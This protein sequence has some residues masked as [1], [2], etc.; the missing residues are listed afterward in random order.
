M[1]SI[2]PEAFEIFEKT[3]ELIKLYPELTD[4]YEAFLKKWKRSH[5][6]SAYEMLA[7]E[8]L[9]AIDAEDATFN[10]LQ[11]FVKGLNGKKNFVA[12]MKDFVESPEAEFERVWK[13]AKG[14]D[15]ITGFGTSD[16]FVAW[17]AATMTKQEGRCFYCGARFV[18]LKEL[19][20][21]GLLGSRA[22]KAEAFRGANPEPDRQES[23]GE[24][25]TYSPD[26][27]VLACYYCNNDKSNVY[28]HSDYKE[29]IAPAKGK[30]I[31]HLMSKL[32]K[33]D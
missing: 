12:A 24:K 30:Y 23:L 21:R 14:K 18:D 25:N 17:W 22:L 31:E 8:T 13:L 3:K 10:Y 29:F 9:W 20:A 19:I 32:R 6:R 2:N 26:N 5:P 4:K 33:G 15:K 27:C 28:R 11:K 7:G 1:T 16:V